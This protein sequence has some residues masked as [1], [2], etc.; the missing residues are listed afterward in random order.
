MNYLGSL[1]LFSQLF[2]QLCYAA[3]YTNSWS[4]HIEGGKENARAIAEEHG[5]VYMG[6]VSHEVFPILADTCLIAPVNIKLLLP[7]HQFRPSCAVSIEAYQPYR[8]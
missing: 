5:F 1:L 3:V 4:A 2:V 6:E 7:V 8:L